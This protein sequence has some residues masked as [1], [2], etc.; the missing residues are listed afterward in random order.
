MT[1]LAH[2]GKHHGDPGGVGGGND[3][4]VS[5]GAAR[6]DDG[7]RARGD[8]SVQPVGKGKKASDAATL[9]RSA[10]PAAS[11]FQVATRAESM[12]LIC[13]APMLTVAPARA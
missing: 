9:P 13:P 12:R 4:G 2:T 8:D 6:L 5:V 11:P 1:E 3:L 7:G 10:R